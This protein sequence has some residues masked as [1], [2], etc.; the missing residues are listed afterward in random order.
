MALRLPTTDVAIWALVTW[1]TEQQLHLGCKCNAGKRLR[2]GNMKEGVNLNRKRIIPRIMSRQEV[3]VVHNYKKKDLILT[4]W[5]Y[6]VR[7]HLKMRCRENFTALTHR[8]LPKLPDS[9]YRQDEEWREYFVQVQN[10][11]CR[12]HPPPAARKPWTWEGVG[13]LSGAHLTIVKIHSI[14]SKTT[15]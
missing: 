7:W 2:K 12:Y 6:K 1:A 13:C 14:Y 3:L 8:V 10:T 11:T 9:S 5:Q 15:W 4:T